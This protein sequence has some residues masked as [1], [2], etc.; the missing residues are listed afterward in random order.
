MFDSELDLLSVSRKRKLESDE[1]AGDA[2][3]DNAQTE[4][5]ETR[6]VTGVPLTTMPGHTGY[7]TFA[8]LP[9]A[10]NT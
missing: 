6:F 5:K 10:L 2:A 9:P 7:L 1:D 8:T 3:G 4:M